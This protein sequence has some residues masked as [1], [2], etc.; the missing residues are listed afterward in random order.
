[1]SLNPQTRLRLPSGQWPDED[2][3]VLA[4]GKVVG[5]IYEDAATGPPF[6]GLFPE[7]LRYRRVAAWPLAHLLL[8]AT[9]PAWL[10]GEALEGVAHLLIGCGHRGATAVRQ[11][12]FGP[13]ARS[14]Q[15]RERR[16]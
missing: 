16:T 14:F 15:G 9:S 6:A 11:Y 4:D 8:W 3:D 2:Y 7:T 5:R 1:V 10:I 13:G 12:D